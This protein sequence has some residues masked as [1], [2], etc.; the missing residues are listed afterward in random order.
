[1][2][3]APQ[4]VPF[5]LKQVRLPDGPFKEAQQIDATYLLSL[6]PQR[7]LHNFRVN[8]GLPSTAQP[9]GGWESPRSGLRGH[10]VGH[11]LSACALMY[12]STGDER[13]RQRADELV[14]EL[15]K[16]Q[17]ALGDGYLSA[18]P[19]SDFDT[20]ETKFTGVWAPY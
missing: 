6:D 4:A 16:C 7:L 3:N 13:F 19:A 9:L 2:E 8:A 10:F 12:A 11:Y 1:M 5:E 17:Q 20:L 18:C 14:S 15:A